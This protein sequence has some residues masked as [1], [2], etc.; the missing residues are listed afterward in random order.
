ML[1]TILGR[2]G[3]QVGAPQTPL[4]PDNLPWAS[5]R[6][7]APPAATDVSTT[8]RWELLLRRPSW[9]CNT[10]SPVLAV[11]RQFAFCWHSTP[12]KVFQAIHLAGC[13]VVQVLSAELRYR[14]VAHGKESRVCCRVR[15]VV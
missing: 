3:Q 1:P 15:V 6:I 10:H 7:Y 8:H 13:W 14:A 2:L 4:R 12:A 11:Y 5:L 9:P